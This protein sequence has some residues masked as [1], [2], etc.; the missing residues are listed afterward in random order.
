M[1]KD[2]VR[3]ITS[4][5]SIDGSGGSRIELASLEYV[6][7]ASPTAISVLVTKSEKGILDADADWVVEGLGQ[8]RN[9]KWLE[10]DIEDD[11]VSVEEKDEF[12]SEVAE[13]LSR[14]FGREVVVWNVAQRGEGK[15]GTDE[16]VRSRVVPMVWGETGD[17][18][19]WVV[20]A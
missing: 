15:K 19:I 6:T 18:Y 13:K 2:M 8:I 9:L 7:A 1:I 17:E 14:I 5:E 3:G 12:C 20:D 4:G 10:I 11:E 16:G